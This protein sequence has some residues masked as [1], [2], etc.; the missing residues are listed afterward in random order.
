MQSYSSSVFQNCSYAYEAHGALN[1]MFVKAKCLGCSEEKS[2]HVKMEGKEQAGLK[3]K[4]LCFLASVH[5]MLL[6]GLVGKMQ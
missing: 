2:L 5:L 4:Q 3:H 1:T 6:V